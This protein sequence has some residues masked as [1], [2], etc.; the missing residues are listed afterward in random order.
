MY[1]SHRSG[2]IKKE[3]GE[4]KVKDVEVVEVTFCFMSILKRLY[5]V[6]CI[7]VC[8]ISIVSVLHLE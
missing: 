5:Y 6:M 4:K 3:K 2:L 1:C 8:I 7:A